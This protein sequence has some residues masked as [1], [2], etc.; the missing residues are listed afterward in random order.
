METNETKVTVL[1]EHEGF[2][3]EHW[4][5][6][7]TF[8]ATGEPGRKA[9]LRLVRHDLAKPGST[10]KTE[11]TI[12]TDASSARLAGLAKLLPVLAQVCGKL[13]VKN[14]VTEAQAAK[15]MSQEQMIAT[16]RAQGIVVSV[17]DTP[18]QALAQAAAPPAS[19]VL[20]VLAPVAPVA[21]V[22]AVSD[23]IANVL[24]I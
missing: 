13:A 1:A 19:S 5:K 16:L 14:A 2:R 10:G 20:E 21:P 22:T 23:P 7:L 9:Y 11:L 3:L 8:G 17:P 4:P 6:G 18:A 24:G 12:P 15:P